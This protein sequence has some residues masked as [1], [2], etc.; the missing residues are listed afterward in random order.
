MS[1]IQA[2]IKERLL[3]ESTANKESIWW[4][5]FCDT[6]KK[7]GSQFVGVVITKALGLA[8]ALKKTHELKINPGGEVQSCMVESIDEK[9]FDKLLGKPELKERGL[10]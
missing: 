2:K 3:E 7:P 1:D 8:H 6:D 5:S 9:H 4:M 10:I